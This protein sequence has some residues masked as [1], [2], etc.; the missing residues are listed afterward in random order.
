LTTSA[1]GTILK[2][3][4]QLTTGISNKFVTIFA[5]YLENFI[6]K[7]KS[8]PFTGIVIPALDRSVLKRQLNLSPGFARLR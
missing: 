7:E 6:V 5:L 1:T 8:R 3:A 4:Q 2:I